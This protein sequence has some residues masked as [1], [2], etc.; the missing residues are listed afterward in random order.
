MG[1][2]SP[3]PQPGSLSIRERHLTAGSPTVFY[4]LNKGWLLDAGAEPAPPDDR[5]AFV[6]VPPALS[7]LL[8]PDVHR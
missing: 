6:Q 7:V 8:K 2:G 4:P 5:R 3:M 1:G